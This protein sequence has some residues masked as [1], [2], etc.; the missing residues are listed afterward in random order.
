MNVDKRIR[1]QVSIIFY[2]FLYHQSPFASAD[3]ND[4]DDKEND[5]M[6]DTKNLGNR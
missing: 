3:L 6:P 2:S 1:E 5:P 4:E